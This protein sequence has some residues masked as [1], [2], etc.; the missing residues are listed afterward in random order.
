[1]RSESRQFEW[2]FKL[3]RLL[4]TSA[5]FIVFLTPSWAEAQSSVDPWTKPLNLSHSGVATHPGLVVDSQG[6]LHV[7]WQDHIAN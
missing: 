2:M 4:F 7:V 1:M 6:V 5:L 3:V